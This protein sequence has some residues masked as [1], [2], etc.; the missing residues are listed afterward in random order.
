LHQSAGAD[1]AGA[2]GSPSF[3]EE[4]SIPVRTPSDPLSD[5]DAKQ[6]SP[7]RAHRLAHGLSLSETARRSGVDIAQL[8]RVENRKSSP[9]VLLLLR[10]A[11]VFGLHEL[12]RLLTPWAPTR[13]PKRGAR[14]SRRTPT[15]RR[16]R[17][18]QRAPA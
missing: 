17:S 3:P 14:K 7:L 4:V 1:R 2:D 13:V 18:R 6:I 15:P 5:L 10:V 9:T 8:S 11:P 16:A 12:E